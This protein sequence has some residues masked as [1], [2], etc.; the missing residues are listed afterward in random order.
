M[1]VKQSKKVLLIDDGKE[2]AMLIERVIVKRNDGTSMQLIN[3]AEKALDHLRKT[4]KRDYTVVLLDLQMPKMTGIEI[5]RVLNQEKRLDQLPP[6]FLFTSSS[7]P[8]DI[9]ATSIFQ[10]VKFKTKPAG[11]LATKA[12]LNDLL[13]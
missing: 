9:E 11:Y 3:D 1:Q 13:E 6:I 4:N 8:K 7:L 10:Q 2:D 12:W 5:L